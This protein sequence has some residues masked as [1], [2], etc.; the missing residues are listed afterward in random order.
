[1]RPTLFP[2]ATAAFVLIVGCAGP[3]AFTKGTYEDPQ[4][5]ALLDDRFSENDLQLIAKTMVNSLSAAPRI[6]GSAAPP[7]VLVG[8]MRNRTTEH[9]D[10]E[11]LADKIRT[12]LVQSGKFR[13]VDGVNRT[14]IAEEYEYQQSGYV[15]PRQAKGPGSQT[16]ADYLLTGTLT[17]NLQEVGK[18][19]LV[20][21]KA[22]F[23]L[24]GLSSSE[25][26]WSE[27]KEIRKAYKKRSIGL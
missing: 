7:A 25:I 13:F 21:Y 20:Y 22:T 16:G 23:Q 15:D 2:I 1:M 14:D 27:E 19:K 18:D 17:S 5:I 4:T 9:I 8:K 6:A 26:L 10:M 3:R 24:T 11:S 12:A